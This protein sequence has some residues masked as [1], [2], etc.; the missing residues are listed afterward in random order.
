M[1]IFNKFKNVWLLLPQNT[2]GLMMEQHIEQK[3]DRQKIYTLVTLSHTRWIKVYLCCWWCG[4]KKIKW[5]F[6]RSN[7][8][9]WRTK[10][11]RF[12]I[13]LSR[14]MS[15]SSSSNHNC[16][17]INYSKQNKNSE[18]HPTN[19]FGRDYQPYYR[20][21]VAMWPCRFV[22]ENALSSMLLHLIHF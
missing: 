21:T 22:A 9:E 15:G 3:R 19:L 18:N 8:I 14:V 20:I 17:S 7:R 4:A 13:N 16:F 10:S 11:N 12:V 6:V 2:I 1:Y 5:N